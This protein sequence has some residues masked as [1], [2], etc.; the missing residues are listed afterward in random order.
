MA[1]HLEPRRAALAVRAYVS[2]RHVSECRRV[3]M[4][5]RVPYHDVWLRQ[6]EVGPSEPTLFHPSRCQRAC[7]WGCQRR[8]FFRQ[9]LFRRTD[10]GDCSSGTF[11]QLVE[12][13]SFCTKTAREE[14]LATTGETPGTTVMKPG[15]TRGFW[16]TDVRTFSRMTVFHFAPTPRKNNPLYGR[17]SEGENPET[18][19]SSPFATACSFL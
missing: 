13:I 4:Q 9:C 16:P 10:G 14:F 18:L 7:L 19:V 6:H 11:R 17:Q 3:Y 12:R 15:N 8:P 5:L 1:V 2:V